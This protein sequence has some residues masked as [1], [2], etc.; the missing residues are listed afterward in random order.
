MGEM[1]FS[2]WHAWKFYSL[3]N[4]YTES[5]SHP[6]SLPEEVGAVSSGIN[7]QELHHSPLTARC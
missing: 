7:Q 1:R 2:S 4:I 6:V 5:G 3:L